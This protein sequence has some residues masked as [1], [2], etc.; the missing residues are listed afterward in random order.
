[1]IRSMRATLAVSVLALAGGWALGCGED[2]PKMGT[3]TGTGTASSGTGGSVGGGGGAG[4]SSSGTGGSAGAGGT[5]IEDCYDGE[6]ND[7]NGTTDCM[8][9]DPA[10]TDLCADPCSAPKVLAGVETQHDDS[11]LGDNTGF[12]A[13]VGTSCIAQDPAVPGATSVFQVT[14][15]QTGCSRC[16]SARSSATT[17]PCPCAAPAPIRERARLRRNRRREPERR[18]VRPHRRD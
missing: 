15:G 12:A 5:L 11:Y 16:G 10:C 17:S 8:D 2:D 13:V 6:D 9:G 3:P 4:G 7:D 18:R 1:M 14:S